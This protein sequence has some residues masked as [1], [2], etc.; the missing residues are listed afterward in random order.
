MNKI[1]W[2]KKRLAI[3]REKLKR[4]KG[5]DRVRLRERFIFHSE[6]IKRHEKAGSPES[7]DEAHARGRVSEG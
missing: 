2:H 4:A 1:A 5:D 3:I 6:E 7:K